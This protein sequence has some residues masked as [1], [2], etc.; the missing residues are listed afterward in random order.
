MEEINRHA[1]NLYS[2]AI[3]LVYHC[4]P[5][6]KADKKLREEVLHFLC[7]VAN[8]LEAQQNQGAS[9]E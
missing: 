4:K 6:K 5:K 8:E 3:Y 2:A 7:V 9:N 1:V